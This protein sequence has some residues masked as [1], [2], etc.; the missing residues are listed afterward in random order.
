M[1]KSSSARRS[2]QEIYL[3]VGRISNHTASR[4][5]NNKAYA[6]GVCNIIRDRA[7]RGNDVVA[8]EYAHK[9]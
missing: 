3:E 8:E 6:R 9:N 7:K 2:V 4:S 1:H 5:T